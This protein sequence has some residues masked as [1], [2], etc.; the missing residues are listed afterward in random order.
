M[1]R[2][3]LKKHLLKYKDSGGKITKLPPERIPVRHAEPRS[4]ENGS[5]KSN[6]IV[7]DRWQGLGE[8]IPEN[9]HWE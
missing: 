5:M 1:N 2:Q 8:V 4:K 7:R 3:E 9:P 6:I